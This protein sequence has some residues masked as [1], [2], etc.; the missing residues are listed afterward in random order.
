[1]NTLHDMLSTAVAEEPPC[2]GGA[3]QVFAQA[4]RLH[5]RHR[6]TVA[7]TGLAG[8][9]AVAAVAVPV[10]AA[11]GHR[12][13]T[14]PGGGFGAPAGPS[15]SPGAS[16][17]PGGPS[18]SPGVSTRP[19]GGPAVD[20]RT[21]LETLQTLLPHDVTTSD[22]QSQNGYASV[23]LADS[24]G[25]AKLEVNV[26]PG[27][28][29]D[30]KPGSG[31]ASLTCAALNLPAGTQCTVNTDPDG[32]VVLFAQGPNNDPRAPQLIRGYVEV[33]RADGVRVVVT[34]YNAVDTAH[35]PATRPDLLLSPERMTGIAISDAWVGRRPGPSQSR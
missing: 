23:V 32:T 8:I 4:A 15:S 24:R 16:T 5:H 2:S 25:K 31:P 3:D 17:R 11:V 34:Q 27:F 35:G 30:G 28:G 18:S 19:G 21:L 12:G 29:T 6:L 7:V 9:L 22:P 14:G 33:R 1:M 13:S 10:S 20:G 26:Q